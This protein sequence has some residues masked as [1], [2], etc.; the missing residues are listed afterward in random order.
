MSLSYSHFQYQFQ[1]ISLKRN[2]KNAPECI[3]VAWVIYR[4]S[5]RRFWRTLE[6]CIVE[7]RGAAGCIWQSL[8]SLL[9]RKES[10]M[11]DLRTCKCRKSWVA[12]EVFLQVTQEGTCPGNLSPVCTVVVKW[13][14]RSNQSPCAVH[15]SPRVNTARVSSPGQGPLM[16]ADLY[17]SWVN[18]ITTNCSRA[19][20]FIFFEQTCNPKYYQMKAFFLK[21]CM[22]LK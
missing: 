22:C 15:W 21:C 4:V 10:E 19:I 1:V 5:T 2:L 8:V 14:H 17:T 6:K 11:P 7:A 18:K 9:A 13:C 20:S 3:I 12:A 16:R